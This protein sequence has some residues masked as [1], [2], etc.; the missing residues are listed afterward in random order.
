MLN[1]CEPLLVNAL[2]LCLCGEDPKKLS[3]GSSEKIHIM[4]MLEPMPEE[5]GRSRLR[6]AGESLKDSLSRTDE[7]GGKIIMSTSLCLYPRLHAAVD[8]GCLDE[9]FFSL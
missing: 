8:K 9:L 1:L 4:E 7:H 2:A 6:E 5:M 3:V